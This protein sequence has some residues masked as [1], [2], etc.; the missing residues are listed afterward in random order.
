M[1]IQANSAH[2]PLLSGSVHSCVTS[3][4]YW[5]LRKY[6]GEQGVEWPAVSYAPMAGLPEIVIPAMRC[7]LGLE[8]TPEAYVGHLVLIFR[9]IKRVL[10]DDAT[11]WA[12]WGD[13]YSGSWGNYA[14]G[15]I[16]GKQRPQ[17]E[18]GQRW[19]RNAYADTTFRPPTSNK[20]NGIKPKDLIMIPARCALALQA[21]GWYLRSDIC[22]EKPN[23]LPESVTDR[24]NKSHEYIFLLTKKPKYFYDHVAVRVEASEASLKRIQ[25]E[26]FDTQTGG[27]KD[28]GTTG[29]NGNRSAWKTLEN[30]AKNPGRNLRTVWTIPTAASSV[31]HFATWP[32][33][34]VETMLKASLS[35]RG[36]CPKCGAQWRRVVERVETDNPAGYNGSKF[37]HGKTVIP[38]DNAGQGQRYERG[39]TIGWEPSC[40]CYGVPTLPDYP[41]RPQEPTPEYLAELARI[42]AER[43]LLLALYDTL[44]VC[45]PITCDPFAGS[46]TSGAVAANLGARFVGLDMGYTY[47]HD[48][49]APRLSTEF[50]SKKPSKPRSKKD[51]LPLFPDL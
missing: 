19:E 38:H 6:A 2:I 13:G 46:G 45:K 31:A 50:E 30:F 41:E 48:I 21:D 12:N 49:A 47:L 17:S 3:P 25:Q 29:V 15:G 22:W 14:P 43:T 36:C 23:S 1:L 51:K 5:G 10:R 8:P 4:P 20:M 11:C 35:E 37:T 27:E 32:V 34:L 33:A 9:E 40:A 16:K 18:D 7:D 24:P 42:R 44:P 28:Y 26:T 39:Q